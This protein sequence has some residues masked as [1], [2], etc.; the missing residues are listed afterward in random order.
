MSS[1]LDMITGGGLLPHVYCKKVTLESAGE[2]NKTNI[3]LSLE[4]YQSAKELSKSSWLNALGDGTNQFLD[5]MF[6]QILQ[7]KKGSVVEKLKPS[8]RSNTVS[9]DVNIY[10]AKEKIG[11]GPR[12]E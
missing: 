9:T 4:L 10:T 8:Y 5:S 2:A 7:Y 6:I 12:K 1:V 11:D 3:T